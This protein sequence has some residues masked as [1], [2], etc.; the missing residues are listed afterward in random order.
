M[1]CAINPAQKYEAENAVL[2]GKANDY[3]YN[4]FTL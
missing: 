4:N 3:K 2:L 1:L